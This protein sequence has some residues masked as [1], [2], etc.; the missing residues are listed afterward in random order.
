MSNVP[1]KMQ[2]SHDMTLTRHCL[3]RLMSEK[4][5]PELVT[6]LVTLQRK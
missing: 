5:G 3:H 4:D 2:P 6:L 1:Y